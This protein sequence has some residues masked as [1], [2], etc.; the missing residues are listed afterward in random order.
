MKQSVADVIDKLIV[1]EGNWV[2]LTN[3]P[4]SLLIEQ[5][6]DQTASLFH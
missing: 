4:N 1:M 2:E 3:N 5:L 6:C